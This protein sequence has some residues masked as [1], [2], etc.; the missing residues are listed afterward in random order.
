MHQF[1]SPAML[2]RAG[3]W[4]PVSI[5]SLSVGFDVIGAIKLGSW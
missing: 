5:S 2:R 4:R 1:T 3:R